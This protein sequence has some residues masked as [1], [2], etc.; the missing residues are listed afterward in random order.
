M[1]LFRIYSINN[2]I[3]EQIILFLIIST[4]NIEWIHFPVSR[5]GIIEIDD[6]GSVSYHTSINATCTE[7]MLRNTFSG[8]K[9]DTPKPIEELQVDNRSYI[10]IWNIIVNRF[11]V[12]KTPTVITRWEWIPSLPLKT[13]SSFPFT[14]T[15][16]GSLRQCPDPWRLA[17][18]SPSSAKSQVTIR[19]SSSLRKL[20]HDLSRIHIRSWSTGFWQICPC[21]QNHCNG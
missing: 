13:Q 15:S 5:A 3:S 4:L 14:W 6:G 11:P 10:S 18:P 16:S 9:L 8:W 12:S 7:N 20:L 19:S 2:N 1:W 21:I 17:S